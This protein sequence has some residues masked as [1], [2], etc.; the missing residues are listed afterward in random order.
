[1]ID[2]RTKPEGEEYAAYCRRRW[3]GDGW[4]GSLRT[5]GRTCGANFAQWLW[6][7]NTLHANRLVMFAGRYGL[8]AACKDALFRLTY[9]E[10]ANTS[11]REVVAS[12]ADEV[13][14]PGGLEFV[15][16]DGGIDEL[17]GELRAA[18]DGAVNAV[19]FYSI[20]GGVHVLKGAQPTTTWTRMLRI[21]AEGGKDGDDLD[22]R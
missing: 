17:R 16:G 12:A 8:S 22:H 20:N 6:W 19:P 13:G 18:R 21:L 15:M 7:P 10:G 3:G 2:P 4:T 11:L 5:A 14:V 1:M 9:E